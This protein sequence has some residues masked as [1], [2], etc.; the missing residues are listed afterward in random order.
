MDV[1]RLPKNKVS[2]NYRYFLPYAPEWGSEAFCNQRLDEL[3]AFCGEAKVDAVQFFVNTLP[4]TYYMPAHNAEEQE[5]WAEWMKKTVRPALQYIKVSY[6]LNF[7][8]LLGCSSYGLDM[9][10]DYDWDFLVNQ[11]GDETLGCACNLSGRFRKIMGK[12]LKLWASTEADII[13]IDDDFRMH[14]H[15][16]KTPRGDC[17]F[18]CYCDIHLDKFAELT[19]KR[20]SREEL[21]AE[22]LKP[23]TPTQLRLQWRKFLGDTMTETADWIRKEVQSVSSQTRMA[24]M[25]SCPDVHSVEG[26][27][28]KE[29]LTALSGEYTPITRPMC[30]NYTGTTVP[31]KQFAQTFR[32]MSQ[33]MATLE[34]I[35]G[36]EGVEFGPELENTRFTTWSKSVGSSKYV[37][38]VAQLLGA[39]QITLSLNDLDGSPINDEPA[40]VPLLRDSKP[41]LQTLADLN[42]R[43]WKKQGL[44]FIDDEN[45]AGKVPLE[46]ENAKMQDLGLIRYWEESLLECGIPAYYGSGDEA[47]AGDN[48]VVLEG[49]TAW[50]PSAGELKKILAGAVLL[51]ADAASVLRKRGFGDYLGVKTGEAQMF[52]IMTEKYRAGVLPGVSGRIP[53]RGSNWRSM[54]CAGATLVSE[55]IDA[56]NRY[57]AGSAI[58]ENSL[59]G[60][61]AVYAGT[62]D[63]SP[64][65]IFGNHLR[66]KWLH[67]ILQWLS[68]AGFPVLAKVPH[69]ALTVVREIKGTRLLALANLGT[70]T[71]ENLIFDMRYKNKISEIQV[72]TVTGE[73]VKMDYLLTET[74]CPG[75]CKVIFKCDLDVFEWFIVKITNVR[76][77]V[78]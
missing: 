27:N 45:S 19:G 63:F 12:M 67:E 74:D 29:M 17:D 1:Y 65:G 75:R 33:S 9:R 13:W 56:K 71:L 22:V 31:V 42:L 11:Y 55:F 21:V 78:R 57:H 61:V 53:H 16:L 32:Y 77:R 48:V 73:W 40:T 3:V 5:H 36:K 50:S 7:Q 51:D 70:D 26:R 76:S 49:Y 46:E 14:N 4:G 54:E 23:G 69:H 41:R 44:M 52:G 15:G 38:T 58:Y 64:R 60:R 68:N 47:A 8:M 2:Y 34:R 10:D 25:T 20:Y 72:L 28:W 37:M 59:G 66:L 35:M 62:G 6:Q 24:L 39:P 18:Y 30:Y 43:D